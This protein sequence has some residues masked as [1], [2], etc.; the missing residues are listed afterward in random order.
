MV[1]A[2]G[3]RSLRPDERKYT[4]SEQ[5][6]LAVVE[7]IKAYKEYLSHQKFTVYTDH[8]ALKWLNSI[9]DPSTRL[10]RWAILLQEYQYEIVHKQGKV[11]Q[12]A[13]ALSRQSYETEANDAS[14]N[15]EISS[16]QLGQA[17]ENKQY[18]QVEFTYKSE[19]NVAIV[20]TNNKEVDE[21]QPIQL[22]GESVAE[23]QKTMQRFLSYI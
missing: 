16:I 21:D 22:Q 19:N 3:G 10:G 15:K 20:E 11:H 7:G 12:N 1:V 23:L 14:E 6:C 17:S 4:V 13:D 5:E 9:K 2:Y 8:H 18:M